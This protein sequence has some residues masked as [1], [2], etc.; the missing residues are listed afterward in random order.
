LENN[1]RINAVTELLRSKAGGTPTEVYDGLDSESTT[2]ALSANQGRILK[3]ILDGKLSADDVYPVGSIYLSVA[4]T[5]LNSSPASWLGGTWELLPEGYALWTG[6][7]NGGTIIGAGL[8]NIT[9]TFQ[10]G[11][12]ANNKTSGAFIKDSTN[13]NGYGGSGTYFCDYSFDASASNSLYGMSNTVQPPAY[14]VYAWK[15][16]A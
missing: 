3:E 11:A 1:E 9:G 16:I 10:G 12:K 13:S 14:I 7:S 15:R 6:H 5:V 2:S 4:K 8:P